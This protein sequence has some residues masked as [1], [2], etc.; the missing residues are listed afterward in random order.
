MKSFGFTLLEAVVAVALLIGGVLVVYASSARMLSYTYDNQYRLVASYL[1]QEG[2]EVIRNIRD[3]NWL[4]E[5]DW[6]D[7]LD[8]G[9]HQ[10]QYDSGKAQLAPYADDFLYLTADG[11]YNQSG[12]GERTVF[13]RK[14]SISHPTADS[15]QIKVEVNWAHD[16]GRPVRAEK[17]IYNWF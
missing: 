2:I 9:D 7:G 3:Q 8:V 13:K 14:V 6:R 4:D 10:L 1:A 17:F 11:V 16:R 15:V 12:D 5:A